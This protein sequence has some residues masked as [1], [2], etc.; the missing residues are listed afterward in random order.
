MTLIIQKS[1]NGIIIVMT[2]KIM[3]CGLMIS[4]IMSCLRHLLLLFVEC[5]N[6]AMPS[7]FSC[8]LSLSYR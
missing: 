2:T 5:Y 3:V 7:A 8:L 1:V 6:N 4:I